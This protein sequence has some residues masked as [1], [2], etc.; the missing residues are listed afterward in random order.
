MTLDL[1]A[2]EQTN[3]RAAL[4]FL[5]FKFCGWE[6]LSTM[7][8]FD[9]TTLIHVVKGRRAVCASLAFRIARLVKVKVDDL[10]AGK[11]PEAGACPHCGREDPRRAVRHEA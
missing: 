9:P 3:V 4:A 6:T 2:Q 1:D 7:L 10:L 8:H 5:R 11:F